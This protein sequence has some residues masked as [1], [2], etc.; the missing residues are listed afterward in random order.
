MLSCDLVATSL[1]YEENMEVKKKLN[2]VGMIILIAIFC[3]PI[4]I[5]FTLFTSSFWEWFETTFKIESY[6]HSGPADWCYLISYV[7]LIVICFSVWSVS[8]R[9]TVNNK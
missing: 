9:R 7:I 4:A 3:I 2:K 5:V 6:G 8:K 1:T